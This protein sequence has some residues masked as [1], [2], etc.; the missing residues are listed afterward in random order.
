MPAIVVVGLQ[1]GDE[2][3]GKIAHFLASWA[4]W[5]L[6]FQ[7]GNNAGHTVVFDGK[8]YVLHLIPGGILYPGKKCL[9]GNGVVID[10]VFLA[11]EM[12]F[13]EKRKIKVKGRLFVSDRAHLIFPYHRHIEAFREAL[14][15][16]VGTTR[17]GIGPAYGDKF[18]RVGIR[19]CDWM[20]GRTFR[21]LLRQNV[22][23]KEVFV[24]E[25]I[26][27]RRLEAKILDDRKKVLPKIRNVVTDSAA[28]I[29]REFNSGKNILFE[30]AQGTML[31]C[32]FGTYPYVTSSN[33]VSGGACVGS[34]LPPTKIDEV[35]GVAKAYVTRVGLGPFP[36]EIKGS[37][38]EYLR[39]KGK[40]YGATT[41]RPRRVGWLDIVALKTAVEINGVKFLCLT[42]IDVLDGLKEVKICK[43]YK[44]KGKVIKSFPAS[45]RIM[46][47]AKPVYEVLPG[48]NKPTRGVTSFAALPPNA[49]RFVRAIES[50]CEV[51]VVLI[52][53]G[54]SREETIYLS[55][56]FPP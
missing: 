53:M 24:R 4:D 43:A 50:F 54:R 19:I 56:K 10:P 36:T 6:R 34:G 7:G 29:N 13:L 12:E 25:F 2:G 23:E 47:T 26:N 33:P 21:K 35:L 16:R 20:D 45:R 46:E 14:K 8:E 3:K 44:I 40:E 30:G 15:S 52:S 41:G 9:I 5:V 37:L 11:G 49:R 27:P 28:L 18:A 22:R 31:D 32:D 17:R 39:K 51:K 55:E 1:W 48:W 38:G 42:K